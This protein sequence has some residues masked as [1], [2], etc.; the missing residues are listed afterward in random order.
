MV[1]IMGKDGVIYYFQPYSRASD[2][3]SRHTREL[4]DV[5]KR[6]CE[7]IKDAPGLKRAPRILMDR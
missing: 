1:E 7:A 2:I 6:V 4:S 3:D 5:E